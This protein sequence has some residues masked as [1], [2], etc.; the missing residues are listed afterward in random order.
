MSDRFY[1][2]DFYKALSASSIGAIPPRVEG[3]LMPTV[4]DLYDLS[5]GTKYKKQ[6]DNAFVEEN[7]KGP[8]LLGVPIGPQ[9]KKRTLHYQT[10][11]G[12][13]NQAQEV[14]PMDEVR[15]SV[16]NWA[17]RQWKQRPKKIKPQWH[18]LKNVLR[19]DLPATIFVK[20]QDAISIS[21]FSKMV[22]GSDL[23]KGWVGDQTKKLADT[24]RKVVKKVFSAPNETKAQRA[25]HKKLDQKMS[26][27]SGAKAFL[28]YGSDFVT[29][30]KGTL[31]NVFS[32]IP[33]EKSFEEQM[34]PTVIDLWR[35]NKGLPR[36]MQE[37][38]YPK[39]DP[40]IPGE[41]GG[42][43]PT[44]FSQM[45]PE[46]EMLWRRNE[47]NKKGKEAGKFLA[48]AKDAQGPDLSGLPAFN[49][50]VY[51]QRAQNAANIMGG[52]M[53]NALRTG[54]EQKHM[55]QEGGFFGP[56]AQQNALQESSDVASGQTGYPHWKPDY[57]DKA[58]NVYQ[59]KKRF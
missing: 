40:E 9:E 2:D 14:D 18:G 39:Y 4:Q 54:V 23:E 7:S 45:T 41:R 27:D 5:K 19:G 3:N 50:N 43:G 33:V 10:P 37:R 12:E 44:E 29:N 47:A 38:E 8:N 1:E 34:T 46:Q 56:E 59:E 58:E 11:S 51:D 48:Q 35:L 42:S 49:N 13:Y 28:K 6:G 20:G 57:R 30:P 53:R 36:Y 52:P 21:D 25:V 26:N 16:G 32:P 31:K 17:K 15:Q 55:A 24:G 22:D